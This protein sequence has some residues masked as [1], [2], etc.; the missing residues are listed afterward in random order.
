M[1]PMFGS[2][3]QVYMDNYYT[4]VDLLVDLL[5]RGINACG[6][7]ALTRRAC[8]I[9]CVLRTSGCSEAQT[10]QKQDLTYAIWMDTKAVLV[11]SNFHDPVEKG[12]VVRRREDGRVQVVVPKMLE[13]YQQYMRGG[14]R[15]NGP[16]GWLLPNPP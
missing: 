9:S 12:K 2:G 1:R 11:L 14:G 4:S 16:A 6:P 7:S 3:L 5:A 13:D 15:C 10:A 8:L